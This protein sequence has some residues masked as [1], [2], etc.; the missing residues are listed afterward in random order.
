MMDYTFCNAGGNV[1]IACP[2]YILKG[3][4]STY[5]VTAPSL[6]LGM[7]GRIY[8]WLCTQSHNANGIAILEYSAANLDMGF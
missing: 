8:T 6:V 3:Q 2:Q 7:V 1:S 5:I 4:R